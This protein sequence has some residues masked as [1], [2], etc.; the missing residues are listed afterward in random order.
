MNDDDEMINTEEEK[1]MIECLDGVERE[2]TQENWSGN[3][4][5]LV[6][7][8]NYHPDKGFAMR[9]FTDWND[10]MYNT[11]ESVIEGSGKIMK[12]LVLSE[13]WHEFVKYH[14]D[15]DCVGEW[16]EIHYD[17]VVAQGERPRACAK[18]YNWDTWIQYLP[19]RSWTFHRRAVWKNNGALNNGKMTRERAREEFERH[20]TRIEM[21]PKYTGEQNGGNMRERAEIME[22]RAKK[23][24]L[25][26]MI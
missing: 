3:V 4:V 24:G 2:V 14:T 18:L 26:V 25:E 11:I 16:Y 12:R 10:V 8:N 5:G 20:N 9:L 23:L 21:S 22:D 6:D 15:D 13:K 1:N 7:F 19:T 17:G